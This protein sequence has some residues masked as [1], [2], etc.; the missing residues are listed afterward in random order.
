[1]MPFDPSAGL[2][3]ALPLA[4][5]GADA[6]PALS[7]PP[8]RA[9]L[10]VESAW[11]FV[12]DPA[13]PAGPATGLPG[14]LASTLKRLGVQ[15][16]QQRVVALLDEPALGRQYR[17][18]VTPCLLLDTGARQVQLPGDPTQLD[19]ARLEDALART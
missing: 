5:P 12:S 4:K 16:G 13:G 17:V 9:L 2:G 1:M 19:A 11:L 14:L 18:R 15:A 6:G 7:P 3:P 8:V 10:V